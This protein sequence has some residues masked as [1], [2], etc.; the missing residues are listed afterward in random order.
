[1][2]FRLN[3]RAIYWQLACVVPLAVAW[4]APARAVQGL[5]LDPQH[6]PVADGRVSLTCRGETLRTRTDARGWFIFSSFAPGSGCLLRVVAPGFAQLDERVSDGSTELRLELAL[7]PL[8]QVV[9]VSSRHTPAGPVPSMMPLGSASLSRRELRPISNNTEDLIRYAKLMAGVLPGPEAVYV[10]GLPAKVLPPAEMI[11]NITV[12]ADPFSAEYSDRDG[13]RIEITTGSPDRKLRFNLGGGSL[14]FGGKNILASGL[15]SS[16]SYASPSVSG[17]IP[18]LPITFSAQGRF[19]STS[20]DQLIQAVTPGNSGLPPS[21]GSVRTGSDNN[22]GMVSFYYSRKNSVHSGLSYAQSSARGWNSGAGGL[23]L[24]DA[25]SGTEFGSHELRGFLEK[26]GERWIWHT[27]MVFD[28]T[29]SHVRANNN[30]QSVDVPGYLVAGGASIADLS[31]AENDWTWKTVVQSN[32]QERSWT[33]GVTVSGAVALDGEVPNLHGKLEFQGPSDYLA[34]LDGGS[35]GTLIREQGTGHARYATVLAAPFIQ[36]EILRSNSAI[37]TGGVRA[38]YQA[39]SG[40][41]LSPR[42]AAAGIYHGFVLRSGGGV[43]VHPWPSAALAQA[44]LDDGVHLRQFIVTGVGDPISAIAGDESR[45]PVI[46]RISPDFLRPRDIMFKE[47]VERAWANLSAGVEYTW[48]NGTHL[49]GSRRVPSAN[50]WTDLLESNRRRHRDATHVRLQYRRKGQTLIANYGWVR[51]YD[52]TD[53]PFSFPVFQ[54]NLHAE[55][56]R[57]TGIPAHT[58]STVGNFTLPS[59]IYLTVLGSWHSFSPYTI[60]TGR[61]LLG[62]ALFNDRAGLPRN[63]G[64]GPAYRSVSMYA[65]RHFSLMERLGGRQTTLGFDAGMQADNLLGNRNYLEL[66]SVVGSPLFGRPLA[67]MP[68]RSLRLWFNLAP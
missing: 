20:S 30:A 41:M 56:A 67:A 53:G 66:G 3:Q 19:N 10:D 65:Y 64:L 2:R 27:G 39:D 46:S 36:G 37:L 49:L 18:H 54:D 11:S 34:A 33:G 22:S 28:S 62:N 45:L 59:K 24:P 38:D 8:R 15:G 29:R 31:A 68:G 50:G 14:G 12:N 55:W 60:L 43:F 51:S 4:G 58:A 1:M 17:A 6:R 23:T 57:S 21:P 32:A 44:L 26:T 47:S 40:A 5:V 13:N 61:D 42:L 7:A 35:T 48:V 63:S 9:R 25:G 16:S 52:D